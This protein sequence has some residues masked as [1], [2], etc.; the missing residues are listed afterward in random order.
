M[1]RTKQLTF[2]FYPHPPSI[3]ILNFPTLLNQVT[4]NL[5]SLQTKLVITV[6]NFEGGAVFEVYLKGEGKF[7]LEGFLGF[8][9]EG[10][11][12]I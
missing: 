2:L 8:K 5:Q 4:D 1:G 7:V 11:R 10:Q 6:F 12:E 3:L 9:D